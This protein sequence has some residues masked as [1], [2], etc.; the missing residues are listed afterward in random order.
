M[1]TTQKSE[2]VHRV[3]VAKDLPMRTR[4]GVTLYT[5][6]YRPDTAGR[7][8]VL[9]VRTPYDKSQE[10]ALTEKEY[11]PPRGYVVVVQD[12]RGRFRSEGEFYPFIHEAQD[13]YDTI[14]WAAG[15]PWSDGNVGTVGQSYLG[16]VQYFA[17]PQQPPHLKA[18]SPVSGPVTYFENCVYR[19]GVFELGWMLAYFVFM[20]RN[21]LERKGRYEQQRPLLDTY[22]SHPEVPLSPLKKEVYR[23]LPLREWGERLKDGAPY[24]A[25]FLQH[26]TDGPYWHATDLRRQLHSVNVPMLHVGSWYD[27]FQYDTLTLYTGLRERAMTP[28]ARHGQKLLMGPWA[29]LLPYAVPTSKGTGEIDFGPEALIEL[30]AAQL[31]WFDHFLK[32]MNT[33]VLDEAPIRLFVMGNNRWRDEYEW[34]LARTRY[35]NLYLHSGGKA[36]SLRGNGQLSLTTPSEEPPDRYLYDPEDPVPTRGGTTLG[37]AMGVFDQTKIEEREDVLVYTGDVL[38]ADMEVTGPV[39]LKLFAASSAPDTDFTAKLVDLRPDGYAQNIAEGVTRAR[40]RESLSSPTLI[41]PEKVYEYTVDLWATSQV[42]K[43]GH[44]L[45]LEVSSSNFPRYDRNPN[46][47]HDFGVD[48]ELRTARQ[49]IFHDSRYPSHLILP[50][51]PR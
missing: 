8:P 5:D 41:T 4:D 21:T 44:R 18:M 17:A 42:F 3:V 28:E 16:L 33:G 22:L 32:G 14:E 45:R 48:A 37:L 25:D 13:G 7:F 27:A 51:I 46:T 31:R 12:T 43:A 26:A 24:F 10:M 50:L 39:S 35:T 19:R 40:F 47:G 11:F 2:A 29:H 30:H 23:H 34:P 15:L 9:V 1:A 49:T 20:A 6:V 36:N 38:T